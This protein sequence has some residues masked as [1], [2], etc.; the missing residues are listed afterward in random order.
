[1]QDVVPGSEP[2]ALSSSGGD[3]AWSPIHLQVP[4]LPVL[5]LPAMVVC[6]LCMLQPGRTVAC[7][8][9]AAQPQLPP[10]KWEDIYDHYTDTPHGLDMREAQEAVRQLIQHAAAAGLLRRS[11]GHCSIDFDEFFEV[12]QQQQGTPAAEL[13]LNFIE[14]MRE[15]SPPGA[16]FKNGRLVFYGGQGNDAC[17]ISPHRDGF[18]AGSAHLHPL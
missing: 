14:K 6:P 1:M 2:W 7:R 18:S 8:R 4:Y 12:M 13:V 15:A 5:L 11:R 3:H 10:L 9:A 17:K 16:Q